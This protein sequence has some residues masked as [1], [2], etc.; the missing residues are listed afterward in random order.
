VP[1]NIILIFN[2]IGN[3]VPTFADAAGVADLILEAGVRYDSV[4]PV[5]DTT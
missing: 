2:Q 1:K 4:G 3:H 5:I